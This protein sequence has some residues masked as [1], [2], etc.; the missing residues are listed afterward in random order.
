MFQYVQ[1]YGKLLSQYVL[2]ITHNKIPFI[3]ISIFS[4]EN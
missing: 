4:M 2:I 1:I 3:I